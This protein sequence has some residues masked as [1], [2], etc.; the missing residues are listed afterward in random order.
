LFRPNIA[1]NSKSWFEN[2]AMLSWAYSLFKHFRN[3]KC[4][5][6]LESRIASLY[7]MWSPTR[8]TNRITLLLVLTNNVLSVANMYL[9]KLET[10]WQLRCVHDISQWRRSSKELKRDVHGR[11]IQIHF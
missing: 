10:P 5:R 1:L 11:K 6:L 4:G 2:K 3:H 9:I 7:S 8:V